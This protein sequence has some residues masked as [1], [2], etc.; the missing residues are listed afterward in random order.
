MKF[1]ST[2]YASEPVQFSEAVLHG[3][4][5]DKGLFMP[6]RIDVLPN[7]FIS[8]LKELSL[9]EMAHEVSSRLIGPALPSDVL[10]RILEESMDFPV[11][12]VEVYPRTYSLELF[13]GPTLAFKD[14][15]ARFLSR[16][17]G[18]YAERLEREITVL[19]ATSGDTGG[20]VANAFYRV[21]GT[22]VIVL[23][24]SQKVS[25]LQEKQFATLDA[26]ITALEVDGTFDDCQAMVKCAFADAK[27]YE[28]LFLTSANSINIARLIPQI[29]YYFFAASRLPERADIVCSV[30]C[31][32]LGNLTAGLIAKRMGLPISSF[33][34]TTNANNVFTEYLQAGT[35]HPRPSKL[36]LSNAMDVGNPSNL[37]RIQDL[38]EGKMDRLRRDVASYTI[39]DVQT[40][41]TIDKI[42]NQCGYILDPHGAVALA[43]LKA[44]EKSTGYKG[45]GIFLETAHPA[46]FAPAVEKITRNE[47]ALPE[48]LAKYLDQEKKSIAFSNRYD[49]LKNFLLNLT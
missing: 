20:A 47:I 4:A 16:I 2:R 6:E 1:Y 24:P 36:T 9:V 11:D 29:F 35:F 19:V 37:E 14:F 30:P 41:E 7:T 5:P 23:Y 44:F 45:N 12:M 39:S 42:Y 48:R 32:N 22:R 31:G 21:P 18:Y 8:H 46:K 49:D 34:A 10:M 3:L 27:L 28:E 40:E 17:M 13:H 26:N 15:G 25:E 43:G 38:Y 33:V